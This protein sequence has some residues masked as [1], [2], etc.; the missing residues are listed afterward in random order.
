MTIVVKSSPNLTYRREQGWFFLW[1][2]EMSR[3]VNW[4]HGGPD[5]AYSGNA[6]IMWCGSCPQSWG[7]SFGRSLKIFFVFGKLGDKALWTF[8]ALVPEW[9][10][11]Y[12]E[13]EDRIFFKV[14]Q[15]QIDKC[16][17]IQNW[18]H[19]F[20]GSAQTAIPS[21]SAAL[22]EVSDASILSPREQL[23]PSWGWYTRKLLKWQWRHGCW[24]PKLSDLLC[25]VLAAS[26]GWD[27]V[28]QMSDPSRMVRSQLVKLA[29]KIPVTVLSPW[30]LQQPKSKT[31]PVACFLCFGSWNKYEPAGSSN[32]RSNPTHAHE[33]FTT[34]EEVAHLQQTA[35]QRQ[36][37]W[38][39]PSTGRPS[40]SLLNNSTP[41][42]DGTRSD[43]PFP[44]KKRNKRFID[45][46]NVRTTNIST[47]EWSR[48][49]AQSN[50]RIQSGK[51][52]WIQLLHCKVNQE[53][54]D[55]TSLDL[56]WFSPSL[57]PCTA[58]PSP[59]LLS[60]PNRCITEDAFSSG[61]QESDGQRTR[62]LVGHA[63]F[64]H[65]AFLKGTLWEPPF[66]PC[67]IICILSP[68]WVAILKCKYLWDGQ[69]IRTGPRRRFGGGEENLPHEISPPVNSFNGLIFI[70]FSL[71]CFVFFVF[72]PQPSFIEDLLQSHASPPLP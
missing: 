44:F 72:I 40:C 52:K 11:V 28:S 30:V 4:K 2:G 54:T 69:F 12:N 21:G 1:G 51:N 49:L 43:L 18:I 71:Y 32:S 68:D 35:L 60:G 39:V 16:D 42:S 64:R 13:S 7:S 37:L 33:H 31:V 38:V 14:K 41:V 24:T 61:G 53:K 57:L 65:A 50:K 29:C 15:N 70:S 6:F 48:L 46:P 67:S 3:S 59:S 62:T 63:T 17:S 10:C 26:V 27:L 55:T 8:S 47:Q 23:E 45:S 22:M 34:P 66:T 20:H 36:Q 5:K 19:Y 25:S 56:G 9:I 58:L